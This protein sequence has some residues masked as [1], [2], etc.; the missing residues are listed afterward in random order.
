MQDQAA[1]VVYS[2]AS[3]YRA[4]RTRS[5]ALRCCSSSTL[6]RPWAAA[7]SS[8]VCPPWRSSASTRAFIPAATR[9]TSDM[10][11]VRRCAAKGT[12]AAALPVAEVRKVRRRTGS[13]CGCCMVRGALNPKSSTGQPNTRSRAAHVRPMG[14]REVPLRRLRIVRSETSPGL[15][16]ISASA[17]F[18]RPANSSWVSPSPSI[19]LLRMAFAPMDRP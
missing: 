17:A 10:P 11:T 2:A 9:A 1:M 5:P 3:A 15:P 19:R 13:S 4:R 16:V 7:F 6:V 12:A 14:R 18:I 8:A